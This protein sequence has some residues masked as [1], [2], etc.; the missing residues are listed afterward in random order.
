MTEHRYHTIS[1]TQGVFTVHLSGEI[2]SVAMPELHHVLKAYDGSQPGDVVVDLG[3]VTFMSSTGLAF[4]VALERACGRRGHTMALCN[5]PPATTRLLQITGLTRFLPEEGRTLSTEPRIR[6]GGV[7]PVRGEA[8]PPLPHDAAPSNRAETVASVES[9]RL[10]R[11]RRPGSHRHS[12]RDGST[13][14][15]SPQSS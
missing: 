10:F 6:D 5:I 9:T 11:G 2:D 14:C 7:R 3:E 15:H 1:S 4:I 12:S 13:R 8:E